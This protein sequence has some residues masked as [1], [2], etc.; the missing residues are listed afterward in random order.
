MICDGFHLPAELVQAISRLKGPERCV[1]VT[2]CIH[3]AGL[4]PGDYHL[5]RTPVR[6]LA[7][8]Q[9]VTLTTP[10]SMGGSTLAMNQAIARYR[11]WGRVPLE[12]AVRAASV[13]PAR[14]LGERY[15]VCRGLERGNAANLT[16]WRQEGAEIRI[17]AVYIGG[18]A[19]KDLPSYV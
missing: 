2:D 14:L 19:G 15:A 6:H 16:L 17:E 1:L 11:A 12:Q 3:V 4:P 9:V 18:L 7:T 13:N 10:S 8:G 5:G